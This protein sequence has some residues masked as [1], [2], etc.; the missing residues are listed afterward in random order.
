MK[1][2]N[3][4]SLKSKMCPVL[5][6]LDKN[7]DINRARRRCDIKYSAKENLDNCKLK[8]PKQ[9]SQH[10]SLKGRRLN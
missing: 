4:I 9:N 3:S 6:N 1:L 10:D 7:L 5:E 2:K 8:E